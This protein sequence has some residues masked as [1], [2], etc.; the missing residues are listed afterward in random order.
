MGTEVNFCGNR[1]FPSSIGY[2]QCGLLHNFLDSVCMRTI[3]GKCEIRLFNI[4][5]QNVFKISLRRA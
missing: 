1:I 5:S 2:I 3:L 4:M